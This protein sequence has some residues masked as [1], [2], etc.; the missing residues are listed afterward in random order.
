MP[1]VV[2]NAGPLIALAKLNLLD[3]LSKLYGRVHIPLAVY[4]EAVIAGMQRGYEDAFRLFSFL[5]DVGWEPEKVTAIPQDLIA[6]GLDKGEKESIALALEKGALLLIDEE[7]GREQAR[8][9]GLKV[10]GTLGI[11]VEAYRHE[12]LT[13]EQL[14]SYFQQIEEDEEIWISSRL[15]HRVLREVLGE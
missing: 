14:R 9:R 10:R 3:I 1:S 7:E 12:L 2:S 11:L 15:C 6:S 5:I 13:S 4:E 8:K